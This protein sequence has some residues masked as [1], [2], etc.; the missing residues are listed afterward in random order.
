M[1]D[2]KNINLEVASFAMRCVQDVINDEAIINRSEYKTL[3]K[4]MSTLIQKNGFIAAV[5]F[6][7]SKNKTHHKRV[8]DNII[9]W[10]I[11]NDKINCLMDLKKSNIILGEIE[12]TCNNRDVEWYI[13]QI[14]KLNQANYRLITKEM[15]NL[16]GWIKRFADGMIEGEE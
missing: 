15:M 1:S 4:K 7:L 9:K 11:K 6:N 2:I 13:E 12:K 8:L 5:V 14:T 16:F 10:N 3:V